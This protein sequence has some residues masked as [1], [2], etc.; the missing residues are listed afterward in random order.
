[1][2]FVLLGRLS[3]FL[4]DVGLLGDKPK[5]TGDGGCGR[6]GME[7]RINALDKHH[8]DKRNGYYVLE[9]NSKKGKHRF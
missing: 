6:R 5:A 4:D 2:M 7:T 8:M 3:L 1:M 9:E